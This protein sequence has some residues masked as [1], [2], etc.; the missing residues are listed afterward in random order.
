VLFVLFVLVTVSVLLTRFFLNI[1][2]V[3]NI[4][5]V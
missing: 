1:G 4:F 5:G 2:R 3:K